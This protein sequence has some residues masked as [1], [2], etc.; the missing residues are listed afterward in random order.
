MMCWLTDHAGNSCPHG[1]YGR[2]DCVDGQCH[3]FTGFT[4][5][6]CKHSQC[7]QSSLSSQQLLSVMLKIALTCWYDDALISY[8]YFTC[9]TLSHVQCSLYYIYQTFISCLFHPYACMFVSVQRSR[10]SNYSKLA[11]WCLS[12]IST[13]LKSVTALSIFCCHLQISHSHPTIIY[14]CK[15]SSQLTVQTLTALTI[16]LLITFTQPS[17]SSSSSTTDRSFQHASPCL[18]NHWLPASLC[19]PRPSLSVSNSPVTSFSRVSWPLPSSITPLLFHTLP[20]GETVR[21]LAS[22]VP[23]HKSF[24]P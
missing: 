1:C 13:G 19:R 12:I 24:P 22:N 9:F 5:W 4:G 14:A 23:F 3:C 6:D 15:T 17:T 2:G 10:Y 16:H 18:R 21:A 11:L 7:F 20:R 8:A